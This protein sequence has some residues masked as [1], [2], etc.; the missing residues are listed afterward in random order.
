LVDGA[1]A[2]PGER[3]PDADK[4]YITPLGKEFVQ[5]CRAAGKIG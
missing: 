3:S 2:I 4:F 1:F 5:A